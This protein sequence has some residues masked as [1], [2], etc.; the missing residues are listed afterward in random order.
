MQLARDW[1]RIIVFIDCEENVVNRCTYDAFGV[2]P[3]STETAEKPFR[4]AGYWYDFET[5]V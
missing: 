2:I 4:Y 1:Q 3:T 5:G